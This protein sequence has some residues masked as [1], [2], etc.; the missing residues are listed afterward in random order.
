MV[1]LCLWGMFRFVKAGC[2]FIYLLLLG[3]TNQAEVLAGGSW[4]MFG[5]VLSHTLHMKEV[6][7]LGLGLMA[8]DCCVVFTDELQAEFIYEHV[9][10]AKVVAGMRVRS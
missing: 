6:W 10:G 3:A 5:L 1:F 4:G 2:F 7:L 8:V 9:E